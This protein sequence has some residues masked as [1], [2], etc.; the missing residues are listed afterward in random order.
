MFASKDRRQEKR[1]GPQRTAAPCAVRD[2]FVAREIYVFV[3]YVY[4]DRP[5]T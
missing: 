5:K 3:I 2:S 1:K 4:K